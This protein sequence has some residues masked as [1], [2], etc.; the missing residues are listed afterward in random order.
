MRL[1]QNE[2]MATCLKHHKHQKNKACTCGAARSYKNR[3]RSSASALMLDNQALANT[4]DQSAE[5][6]ALQMA[7]THPAQ[8]TIS[9]KASG[10]LK[11]TR[12]A[13]VFASAAAPTVAVAGVSPQTSA[14]DMPSLSL[15]VTGSLAASPSGAAHTTAGM[16]A[17]LDLPAAG[18]GARTPVASAAGPTVAVAGV[19]HKLQ[20]WICLPYRYLLPARWR[21]RLRVMRIR[22]ST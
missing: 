16:P 9:R 17:L 18:T 19:V 1:G 13:P 4:E 3:A 20:L 22:P 14:L 5:S 11:F 2:T 6:I 10:S 15:S 7:A 12:R 8:S 21:H